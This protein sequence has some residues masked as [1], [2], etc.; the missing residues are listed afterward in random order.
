L[1][2]E[3]GR[4]ENVDATV[5]GRHEKYLYKCLSPIP[6]RRYRKRQRYLEAAIPKGFRKDMLFLNGSTVGQIEYAP[7]EASGLPI[8]GQSTYVLNCIWVLRKAKG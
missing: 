5:G 2:R 3:I 8:H 4:V 6:F 1:K 7:A